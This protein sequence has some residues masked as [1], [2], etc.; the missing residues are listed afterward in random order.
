[1]GEELIYGHTKQGLRVIRQVLQQEQARVLLVVLRS[2]NNFPVK[3]Q[4]GLT[5]FE[6]RQQLL[7][8]NRARLLNELRR[9]KQQHPTLMI[10]TTEVKEAADVFGLIPDDFDE[11][12]LQSIETMRLIDYS[13]VADS[14]TSFT[15][16]IQEM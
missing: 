9:I 10:L 7:V 6:V 2:S 16:S 11:E 3:E 1:V 12:V 13:K 5:Q 14:K 8:E 15:Y 4:D